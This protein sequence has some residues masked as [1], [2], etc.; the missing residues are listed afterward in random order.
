MDIEAYQHGQSQ[1]DAEHWDTSTERG[2]ERIK[3][4]EAGARADDEYHMELA[5][6][7]AI[8]KKHQPK[9]YDDILRSRL[10]RDVCNFVER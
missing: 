7:R 4:R 1:H 6:I 10:N 5:R 8:I 9:M 3:M 2:T